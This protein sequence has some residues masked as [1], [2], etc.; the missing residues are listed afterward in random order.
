M[1]D[2]IVDE[3]AGKMVDGRRI[4]DMP[5]ASDSLIKAGFF[6]VTENEIA[7][8]IEPNS[9]CIARV[10]FMPRERRR[11]QKYVRQMELSKRKPDW[12]DLSGY[13]FGRKAKDCETF[14]HSLRQKGDYDLWILSVS[15]NMCE[16]S[17]ESGD[18]PWL[19]DRT[20][21]HQVCLSGAPIHL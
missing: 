1:E 19:L 8:K 10:P 5:F 3:E 11:I 20:R 14:T 6:T 21:I 15:S 17:N 9:S 7:G 16:S 4:I 12:Q 2:L 13:L 18:I